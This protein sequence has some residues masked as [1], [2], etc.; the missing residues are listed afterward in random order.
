M[1]NAGADGHTAIM[2]EVTAMHL[3]E[4]KKLLLNNEIRKGKKVTIKQG[5]KRKSAII[6]RVNVDGTFKV[7][8]E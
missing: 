1:K 2:A 6:T 4:L 3:G 7:S 8:C 5:S